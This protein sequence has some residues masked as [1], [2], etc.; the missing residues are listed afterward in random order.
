MLRGIQ[1]LIFSSQI[2]WTQS[3]EKRHQIHRKS[4]SRTWRWSHS[5]ISQPMQMWCWNYKLP[6]TWSIW[7]RRSSNMWM[8]KTLTTLSFVSILTWIWF[9]SKW[10]QYFNFSDTMQRFSLSRVVREWWEWG[11]WRRMQCA[12]GQIADGI[13]PRSEIFIHWER[14]GVDY[15]RDPGGHWQNWIPEDFSLLQKVS[16]CQIVDVAGP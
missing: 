8:W 6:F 9:P 14:A 16:A 15:R 10:L 13:F 1:F 5:R 3:S 2:R 12:I 11:A 4:K 7:T